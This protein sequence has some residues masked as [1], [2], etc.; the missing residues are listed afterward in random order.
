MLLNRKPIFMVLRASR[1]PISAAGAGAQADLPP[2]FQQSRFMAY[3]AIVR[4]ARGLLFWGVNHT[5]KPSPFW[6]GLRQLAYELS[7]MHD[8][9]AGPVLPGEVARS[10]PAGRR[11]KR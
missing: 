3:H 8:V 5:P 9:L 11:L 1:G 10:T 7:Q 4:G 2:S 6:N